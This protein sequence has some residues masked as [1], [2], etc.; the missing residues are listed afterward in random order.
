MN[1]GFYF[2]IA[3]CPNNIDLNI[4][5]EYIKSALLYADEISLISPM[6]FLYI[7]LS[8]EKNQLNERTA[9]NLINKVLLLC[10]STNPTICK[11]YEPVIKEF[12]KTI[13]DKKYK[14][15]PLVQRLKIKR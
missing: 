9:L 8:D 11:E 7:Q 12:E 5:M 15:I 14:S 13:L 3:V 6:A 2:N 4:E 1:N 10:K